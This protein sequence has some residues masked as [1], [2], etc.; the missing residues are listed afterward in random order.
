M[1]RHVCA[2]CA[3][4][5]FPPS[6]AAWLPHLLS[7]RACRAVRVWQQMERHVQSGE[8]RAL[9]IS[10]CYDVGALSK[11]HALAAVKPSVVQNRFHAATRYDREIRAFCRT[12]GATY[13]S[14][15]TLTANRNIIQGRA[16]RDVARAH[17]CTPE[18]AWL[19]FVR[20]LCCV[21]L[22]GTTTDEHM[23][24]DLD[25]P[26]LSEAEVRRLSQLID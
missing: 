16:V 11:L 18:Q 17:G 26:L 1:P 20:A 13:Q 4:E 8:V 15:W 7:K 19:G 21:P 22:S 5:P 14:F 24:H 9:G 12:H 10:N 3:P 23:R 25:L 6:R 2:A